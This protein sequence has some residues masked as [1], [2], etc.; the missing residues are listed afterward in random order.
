[1]VPRCFPARRS[2]DLKDVQVV[3]NARP[4][5]DLALSIDLRLQ[6]LAHR[7]LREALQ[8]FE[9]RAGSIV[10]IDVRTGEVLALANHPSYNPNNRAHLQPDAMRNRA[11]I[12][13]VEPGSTVKPMS[14]RSALATGRWAPRA[15]RNAY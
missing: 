12:D 10:M 14:M 9:A 1:R 15:P 11:L 4:G 8:E 7:Q 2:S 13:V 5:N 3:S 6:Y